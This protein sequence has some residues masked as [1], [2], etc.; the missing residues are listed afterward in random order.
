MRYI[1]VRRAKRKGTTVPLC[2]G[3]QPLR[4]SVLRFFSG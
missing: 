3:F 1:Q 2:L 4:S